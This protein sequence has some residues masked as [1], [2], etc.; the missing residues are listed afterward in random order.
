M[1]RLSPSQAPHV[2][3]ACPGTAGILPSHQLFGHGVWPE[4]LLEHHR[5][6]RKGNTGSLEGSPLSCRGQGALAGRG[7]SGDSGAGWA[8]SYLHPDAQAAGEGWRRCPAPG[9][10]KAILGECSLVRW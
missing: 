7:V 5:G 2:P 8:G 4:P 10:S 9:G 1:L 6:E 3:E